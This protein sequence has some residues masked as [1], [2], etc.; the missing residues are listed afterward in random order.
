MAQM[1]PGIDGLIFEDQGRRGLFLPQVWEQLPGKTDFLA[2]LKRKA[3]FAPKHW[4]PTVTV[5]RF[6]ARSIKSTDLPDPSAVWN[7]PA[8]TE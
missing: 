8:D 6:T 3:G 7:T 5:H 4:T 2:H 1:R